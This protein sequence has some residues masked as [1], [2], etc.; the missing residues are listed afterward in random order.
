MA[1]HRQKGVRTP[2]CAALLAALV[3]WGAPSPTEA[4]PVDAPPEILVRFAADG[5]FA[6][7]ECAEALDRAGRAFAGATADGSDSL[8]RLR[9]R[10]GARRVRALFRRSDGRSFPAQRR[11]LRERLAARGAPSA[12]LPDLAHVYR[13]SLGEG[14]SP[15]G[16]AALYR[17]DPHVVWAQPDFRVAIDSDDVYFASEGSWGQPYADLWGL[18]RVRAPSAWGVSRGEGVVVAVID[19]GLDPDHP[20]IAGNVFV[21]PGEDLDGDGIAEAH[22][23]NGVDDDGNGFVDDL[24]GWDFINSV[25]GDGDGRFDGSDDEAD[26]D[27]FDDHGHGTH[28]SGTVAA[29]AGNGIGIAGVA[30][31]AKILPLKGFDE[32]GEGVSSK[33]ARA[34]VYAAENGASVINN[35]WSCTARCPTNPVIEEAVRLAHGLDVVVVTSA[36]NAEDDVVHRSPENRRET[37]VVSASTQEDGLARF[38]SFGLLVDVA[39]PGGGIVTQPPPRFSEKNVLSLKSSGSGP[40]IDGAGELVVD[41]DYVRASGTSMSSPHV[42]GVA[43]LLLAVHPEY[44][45]D[46]VRAVLRRTADDLGDPGH[47]DR[48]GKR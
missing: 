14:V 21:H 38:S 39:A 41:D 30:P 2:R 5:P 29:V 16:A 43:A 10:L 48:F 24:S 44:G 33:L 28:V 31:R 46:D 8:D 15:S 37:I 32:N 6:L 1:D 40:G 20:D 9:A 19:T 25:D 34:I 11:A 45:P 12:A 3:A 36:G 7:R 23:R 42:A 13:V 4:R 18:H 17:E 26:A 35:S 22:E 47:D 27:P